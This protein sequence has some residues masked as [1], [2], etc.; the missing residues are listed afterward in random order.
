MVQ[1]IAATP[2]ATL[3]LIRGRAWEGGCGALSGHGSK[4]S[5]HS[6]VYM[7]IDQGQGIGGFW[8]YIHS[9]GSGWDL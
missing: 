7:C 4:H 3:R 9:P 2:P 1:S 6:N 8:D 5:G